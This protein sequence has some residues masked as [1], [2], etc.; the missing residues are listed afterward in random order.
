M[1]FFQEN[2]DLNEKSTKIK[3]LK[4]NLINNKIINKNDM[5]SIDEN[6]DAGIYIRKR[7]SKDDKGNNLN[8]KYLVTD[9]SSLN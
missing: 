8:K 2:K 5:N 1:N 6:N 3:H 4:K 7:S 9:N